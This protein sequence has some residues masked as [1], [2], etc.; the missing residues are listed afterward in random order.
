VFLGHFGVTQAGKKAAP[1][2]SL[3]VPVGAGECLD[4]LWPVLLL[5]GGEHVRVLKGIAGVTPL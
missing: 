1:K 3:A 4:L 2:T 5:A